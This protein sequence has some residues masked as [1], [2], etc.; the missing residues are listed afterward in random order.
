MMRE[1][2]R[3]QVMKLTTKIFG[4]IEIDDN[5]LIHF[6]N[7]I[8]GFPQ[9]QDFVLMHDEENGDRAGIRWLQS[10]QEPH[11]A[12]PVMDPLIVRP[13]YN[14]QV[15]DECFKLL[16][17]LKAE[18]MLVLVSVTVPKDL[19]LMSVNLKAPFIINAE[20]RKAGQ[21]I[22]DGDEYPVKWMIYDI[23]KKAKAGE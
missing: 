13:D 8:V 15:D 18:N 22:V 20:E 11:F 17:D 4:A 3:E 2:E 21:Y 19:K 10:I 23:L 16:G 14:P 12:I 9:L 5:K 7:G 1:G 6:T